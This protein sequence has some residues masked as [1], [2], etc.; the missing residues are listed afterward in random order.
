MTKKNAR[1]NSDE[2]RL[3][4]AEEYLLATVAFVLADAMERSGLT[5]YQLAERLGVSEARVSQLLNAV[6]N[7]TVRTLA[8]VAD[9]LNCKV[10]MRFRE[11]EGAERRKLAHVAPASSLGSE[12]TPGKHGAVNDNLLSWTSFE[13]TRRAWS[14]SKNSEPTRTSVELDYDVAL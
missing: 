5:Q 11:L 9:A 1:V 12:P 8:R 2:G 10:H 6:G 14:Q 3:L 7:P 13:T 4:E